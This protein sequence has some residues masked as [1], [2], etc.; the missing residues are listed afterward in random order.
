M[1]KKDYGPGVHV[2]PP[3][4]YAVI[5]AIG[6]AARRW[7]DVRVEQPTAAMVLLVLSLS[8]VVWGMGTMR[9]ARTSVLPNRPANALVD[10]GPFRFSRNPLYVAMTLGYV[11]AALA[12]DAAAA[13]VLL[14]V[15][16][17]IIHFGVIKREEQYLERRFGDEYRAYCARV[18]RWI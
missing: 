12:V 18:R 15:A 10:F 6:V 7:V 11:S 17:A 2:P 13:L 8:V 14:P 5:F 4:I 16:V 9:R 1:M 3:V